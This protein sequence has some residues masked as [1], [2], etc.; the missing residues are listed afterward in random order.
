MKMK[1][2]LILTADK[3]TKWSEVVVKKTDQ[4]DLCNRK[5]SL[6]SYQISVIFVW[7]L[8]IVR[9]AEQRQE[10]TLKTAYMT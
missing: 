4:S 3:T 8:Q 2:I 5:A 6:T 10:I 7:F 9:S 1:V